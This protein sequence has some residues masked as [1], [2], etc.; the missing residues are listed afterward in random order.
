MIIPYPKYK[1]RDGDL[2][3]L[4]IV[5]VSIT[6]NKVRLPLWALL[7]SGADMTL[8]NASFAQIFSIDLKKG[9]KIDLV[10]VLEGTEFPA[11]LHQV[12]LAIKDVGSADTTRCIY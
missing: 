9:R 4:P 10:G 8:L 1:N 2:I 6:C 5:S 3:Q 12:N 11:Y 7:D